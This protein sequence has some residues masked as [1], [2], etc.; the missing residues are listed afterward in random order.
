MS[1]NEMTP[2]SL[3]DMLAPIKLEAGTIGAICGEEG[4]PPEA[5]VVIPPVKL[6]GPASGVA[7]AVGDGDAEST[8]HI[9]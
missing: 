3:P 1:V 9:R 6:P 5:A 8:T 4:A 7:G 2:L